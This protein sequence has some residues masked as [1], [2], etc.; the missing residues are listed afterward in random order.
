MNTQIK[1]IE[2]TIRI[3]NQDVIIRT[4]TT[5]PKSGVK[6]I[7]STPCVQNENNGVFVQNQED[8]TKDSWNILKE[9]S[10]KELKRV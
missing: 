10:K 5:I 3:N 7:K 6:K 8:L 2:K 4:N 1:Q 9:V